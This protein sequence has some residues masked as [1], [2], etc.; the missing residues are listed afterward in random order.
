MS[1]SFVLAWFLATAL[2]VG[3]AA[4]TDSYEGIQSTRIDEKGSS[5]AWGQAVSV[6]DQPIDEVLAVVVDYANYQQFMPNFRTSRVLAKRGNRAMVYMEVGVMKDTYTLW[7][8]L[9]MSELPAEDGRVI[10][11]GLVEGNVD[12]F[13]AVWKLTPLDEG[14]R[15]KVDF[16]IYVDPDMPLPSSLFSRE[17][18]KAAKKTV[19][20]LRQRVDQ[21]TRDS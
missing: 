4:D 13:H 9:K 19:R 17:N 7:G 10:D 18:V 14:A 21:R 20:A 3:A 2:S 15:T 16:R 5:I 11:V 8:Q 6:L 12:A 1:R